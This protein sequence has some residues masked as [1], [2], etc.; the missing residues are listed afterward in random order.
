[1]KIQL[2]ALDEI[3]WSI[4]IMNEL[5]IMSI[6]LGIKTSWLLLMQLKVEKDS[7]LKVSSIIILDRFYKET[8]TRDE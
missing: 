3:H 8:N 4:K 7:Q 5:M 2:Y 6:K 1:M